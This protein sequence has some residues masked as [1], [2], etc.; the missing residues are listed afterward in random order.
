MSGGGGG[1][2]SSI[3]AAY[4]VIRNLLRG[5]RTSHD[6]ERA[7]LD[8]EELRQVQYTSMGL[9]APELRHEPSTRLSLLRRLLRR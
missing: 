9:E 6:D 2:G 4:M 3:I 8:A 1:G 7:R 5:G